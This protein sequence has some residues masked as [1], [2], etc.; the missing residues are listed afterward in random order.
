M[1][2]QPAEESHPT[3]PWCAPCVPAS[4]RLPQTRELTVLT[5]REKKKE[6]SREER[7][8]QGK[9]MSRERGELCKAS[10]MKRR[11][12]R[13]MIMLLNEIWQ[14]SCKRLIRGSPAAMQ[15]QQV[16]AGSHKAEE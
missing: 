3:W 7:W 2:E 11:L 10:G 9:Q 16:S 14:H 8:G 1:R 4:A 5:K 12:S 13:K 6:E 15:M